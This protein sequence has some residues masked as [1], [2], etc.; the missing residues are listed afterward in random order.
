MVCE[1]PR[2]KEGSEVVEQVTVQ[3]QLEPLRKRWGQLRR[4]RRLRFG[5]RRPGQARRMRGRS[6]T[7]TRRGKTGGGGLGLSCGGNVEA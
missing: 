1:R 5:V 3:R 7:T 6:V 2:A 4:E